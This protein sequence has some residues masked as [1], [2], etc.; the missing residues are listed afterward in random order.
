M[1]ASSISI[2]N[3]GIIASAALAQHQAVTAAGAIATAAGNA[4]G[5]THTPA[6]LGERVA[7]TAVGTAIA[8]AGGAI[9]IG[10][11]V[12]VVGSV[13]KVAT[14]TTG[15]AIGRALTAAA[16]DGDQVEVL[17]IAN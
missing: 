13:G 8:I 17:I 1:A 15:I 3:L 7:V 2:L 5:F 11:A 9:A 14:K 10:A 12:E 16:A 4:V 6:A